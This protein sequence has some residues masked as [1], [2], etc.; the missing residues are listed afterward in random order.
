MNKL[1]A[2]GINYQMGEVA[3]SS[4]CIDGYLMIDILTD[5]DKAG[6]AL[7]CI[8]LGGLKSLDQLQ[9]R[10]FKFASNE[11]ETE[12]ELGESVVFRSQELE[13][14]LEIEKLE[15]QFGKISDNV[16]PIALTARCF[17][18][19]KED[20]DIPVSTSFLAKMEENA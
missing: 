14:T 20:S 5:G 9:N 3:I 19:T 7:N 11:D 4:R 2:G 6:I 10:S 12:N 17:G 15:I 16:F 18:Y 13:D 1:T 8:S